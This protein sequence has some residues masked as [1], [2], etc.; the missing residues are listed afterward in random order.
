LLSLSYDNLQFLI[1]RDTVW[2]DLNRRLLEYHYTTLLKRISSFQTQST[3]E[4]YKR[5]LQEHPNIEEQVPL[6]YI[7]SYLGMTQETLSRIRKKKQHK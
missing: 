4:R 1:K 7:A 6:G 5:L 3:V 2:V